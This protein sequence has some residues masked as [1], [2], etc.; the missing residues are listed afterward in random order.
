VLAWITHPACAEHETGAGHPERPARLADVQAAVAAADLEPQ[1]L[2][3]EAP[4]ATRA[5]LLR[6]HAASYLD[7]LEARAPREG[8]VALDADTPMGPHSLEAAWR[9]AGA[10]VRGVDGVLGGEVQGA[11]CNVRPPGHHAERARAMGFC[12]L[13]N[14]AVGVAHALA[15]HGLERVAVV[16]FDVHHGNGTQALLAEET[17]VLLCSAFQH[18]FYPFCGTEP[19]R[20]GVR[21]VPVPAG[22][23][24]AAWRRAVAAGWFEALEDF[25]PQLLFFSAGFDGHVEDDLARLR[26]READYGWITREVLER[27]RA[28]AQGRAVSALEG[29]YAL[30]ALGRS[31]LAHVRA[32]LGLVAV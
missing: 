7:A 27:T 25:A 13:G 17:R 16:D 23:D 2:R 21:N 31:V 10:V 20:A 19:A 5:Q 32:L 24:G 26:L 4:R 9:A 8:L 6:V 29:G 12:L 18:P 15:A 3:W 14:V 11:F 28:S 22:T 30:G 1:L